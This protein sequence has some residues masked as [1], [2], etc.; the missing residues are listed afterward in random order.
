MFALGI[1]GFRQDFEQA[2][3]WGVEAAEQGN[4]VAQFNLGEMFAYG[5]GVQQN[6]VAG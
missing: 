2:R 5:Y 4:A 6:I 3:I 1:G